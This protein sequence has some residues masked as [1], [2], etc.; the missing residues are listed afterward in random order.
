MLRAVAA[1]GR[2]L[3]SVLE[4]GETE[5]RSEARPLELRARCMMI[6]ELDSWNTIIKPM[7]DLQ[8]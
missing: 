8:L 5:G 4:Y 6:N 7:K 2:D 3:K 1:A